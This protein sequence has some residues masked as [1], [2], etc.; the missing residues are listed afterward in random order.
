MAEVQRQRAI[1]LHLIA[2]LRHRKSRVFWAGTGIGSIA[3]AM[4]LV[5]S[6]WYAFKLN[7]GGGVGIV[8]FAT[9][10][11]M[12]LATP[13]GGLLADR[14]DRR[15]LIVG[16]EIIQCVVAMTL[17]IAGLVDTLPFAVFVGFVFLSGIARAVELTTTQAVVPNLVP[18]AELLNVMAMNSLATLGSRFVGPALVAPILASFGA[19]AAYLLIA[20]LY[21]PAVT[22]VLRIPAMPRMHATV[23]SLT[24]QLR[25]G[26]SYIRQRAVLAMLLGVVVLHCS[27][28][29]SFDS[30]LPLIAQENLRG[31]SGIYSSLVA[32]SGLGAIVAT[33]LLAGVRPGARRGLIFLISGIGSGVAA[34]LMALSH[35]SVF[36][37][38]ALVLVGASQSTFM[39]LAMSF[40]QE[41][42]PDALR[43]RVGGLF[44]MSAGGIMSFGNLANGYLADRYGATI[45]LGIPAVSFVV[46]LFF[47]SAVRPA[48]RRIYEEGHLSL[49]TSGSLAAAGDG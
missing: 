30:T 28:T 3:Q 35:M 19:R 33:L 17:G 27:L 36:A 5:T 29:M 49:D 20:A 44:L 26:G 32:A 25:E 42:L 16:V 7:G 43:G 38:A 45:I 15:S 13:V 6:G 4:F 1:G 8:T 14:I 24:A 48:L 23:L 9:M 31:S 2:S 41:S 37:L 12:L 11:P 10:L 34:L 46:L 18:R 47:I 39:T 40:V 22:L 21:F